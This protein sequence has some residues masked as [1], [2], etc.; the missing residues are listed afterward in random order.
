MKGTSWSASKDGGYTMGMSFVVLIE[1]VE[2]LVP[3]DD[4]M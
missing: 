2:T 4:P 1:R 3:A